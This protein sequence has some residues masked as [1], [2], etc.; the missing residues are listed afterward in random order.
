MVC[1]SQITVTK[2]GPQTWPNNNFEDL[3]AVWIQRTVIY[4]LSG[5]ENSSNMVLKRH[6]Y[7]FHECRADIREF[8]KQFATPGLNFITAKIEKETTCYERVRKR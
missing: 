6:D 7:K 5:N 8:N 1:I 4:F 3:I 2:D